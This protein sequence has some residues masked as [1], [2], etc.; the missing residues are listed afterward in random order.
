NF[1][2]LGYGGEGHEGAYL[3]DTM[4]VAHLDIKTNK[5]VLI[6]LPRDLWV[7]VPG[8]SS[9]FHA[10]INSIYQMG[11]FSDEYPA[12]DKKYSDKQGAAELTKLVVGEITGLPI[13]NYMGIDFSG[14]KEIID[15]VGGV[16]INVEKTFDDYE[17][18]IEG[19]EN[20]LC[21]K[22]DQFKQIEPYLTPPDD[23]NATDEAKLKLFQEKPELEELL[24][25]ITE[26]PAVAFPCR[27]EHLHFDK[28]PKHM[29]GTTALKYAR[30]RHSLQDGTDFGRARRQQRTIESV[31][32]KVFSIAFLPK[33]LPLMDEGKK[34]VRMDLDIDQIK[35]LLSEGKDASKYSV[36]SI[37]P[38]LEN[39]M[40]MN[41]V[42]DGG[43]FILVPSGGIDEYG[44]MKKLIRDTIDGITPT[45]TPDPNAATGSATKKRVTPTP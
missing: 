21:G 43:Q 27:Y 44:E 40:L 45:P 14:F 36:T 12:I 35:K 9:D 23:P 11:L 30:S 34:F 4:M 32:E 17:Y 28:G 6:S 39:D 29:D 5:V 26:D 25:N 19:K 22:E 38:S 13:D 16:D 7:K 10:K 20:D 31:K 37:V 41:S 42:S 3:T 1:L 33:I 8:K 18:P 2:L 24:K 15:M